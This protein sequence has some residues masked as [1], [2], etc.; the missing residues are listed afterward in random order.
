MSGEIVNK[1]KKIVGSPALRRVMKWAQC[2]RGSIVLIC[3]LRIV[4]VLGAFGV[5]LCTKGL[6][7]GAVSRHEEQ[8]L[9]NGIALLALTLA[10]VGMGFVHSLIQTHASAKLQRSLQGMLV[11]EVLHKEYAS[12]KAYHSG[13]LVNRTFSD[14]GVIKNGVLS[15]LPGIVSTG[16]SFVG[17]LSILIALDWRFV[18]ILAAA[19]ILGV[20]IV[21]LFRGPMK[22]RFRRMQ[23]AEDGLHAIIQESFANIRIIKAS[24][25]ENRVAEKISERQDTLEKEQIRQGRFSVVMNNGMG[26]TFDVTWLL[27][28]LWG[29]A[30]I[31][32]GD[33]SYGSLAAMIQ[34]IGRV[35]GPIA[36]AVSIAGD[37]Y[38]VIASAERIMEMT[39]LPDEVSGMPLKDFDEIRVNGVTFRYEDG[40]DDVLQGASCT[41]R[42]G[43]FV[44]LTG[45]SGGGK[46]SL[47]HLLL[48][49]YAPSE[50]EVKVHGKVEGLTDGVN[51]GSVNGGIG[52]DCRK[53]WVEAGVDT[54]G[55]FAYVPQGNY[56]FSGT[57]RENLTMFS[58]E[59]SQEQMEEAIRVACLDELVAEIGLDAELGERGSGISE[60]QAQR[61]AVARALI[62]GA[63]ILLLDES[64]SA[65]DE[66]TEARMLKNL[67]ALRDKTCLIVTHRRAA[68]SVC[69]RELRISDGKLDEIH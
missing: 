24:S 61:V 67:S 4:I 33:L 47:F 10:E 42:K 5:T 16:V 1:L 9:R 22:R 43:D 12:L 11:R 53:A 18:L 2:I 65:L 48:G 50:G 36:S 38:R 15:V 49:I 37:I 27:C 39:E 58:D 13:E 17:A 7:D 29:S 20:V 52:Q 41:I 28:M 40:T 46:S 19:G 66:E 30:R 34:L 23:Q 45:P 54:R 8:M 60:G 55:L 68:L 25:S 62:K 57:L 21:L 32:S 26:L 31:L 56:L 64:T 63:E 69:N 59:V 35:Q 6:I 51:D 3:V 44:A 14:I